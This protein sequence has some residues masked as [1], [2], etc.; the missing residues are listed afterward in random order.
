MVEAMHDNLGDS[1]T[2]DDMARTA[3]FSKYHFIRLF[4]QTTGVTPGRFL[5]ALRIQEA[6]RL[7]L[8]TDLSVAEISQRVGYASVG[9]FSSRFKLRVGLSPSA[10]REQACSSGTA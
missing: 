7:L 8:A 9:T 4:R 1:F 3:V 10:Y 2:A 6:Q 5:A